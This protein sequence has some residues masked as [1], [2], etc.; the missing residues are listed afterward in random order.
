M[1]RRNCATRVDL[2][3]LSEFPYCGHRVYSG[4]PRSITQIIRDTPV[5]L[6]R[7]FVELG[8]PRGMRL[9]LQMRIFPQLGLAI[10]YL[11]SPL[12]LIPESFFGIVGLFDDLIV[13]G[14]L[15]IIAAG[16]YRSIV[17]DNAAPATA[18]APNNAAHQHRH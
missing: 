18:P 9:L 8:S 6:R 1:G 5:L 4:N 16:I 7:L 11:L 2:S 15:S 14:L 3:N 10:L 12:D 13:I 17:L